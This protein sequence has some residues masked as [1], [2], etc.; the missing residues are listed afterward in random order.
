MKL[1]EYA[2]ICLSFCLSATE[3]GPLVIIDDVSADRNNRMNSEV[4]RAMFS[5]LIQPNSAE[6]IR[7]MGV[8]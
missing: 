7:Q 8:S 5:A 1:T 4:Y 6:L 3:T 2:S